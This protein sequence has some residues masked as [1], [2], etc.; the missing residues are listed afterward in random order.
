MFPP[1]IYASGRRGKNWASRRR[2]YLVRMTLREG[3]RRNERGNE[4]K[5]NVCISVNSQ[6]PLNGTAELYPSG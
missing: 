3:N 6:A 1:E 2:A 5:S 4:R